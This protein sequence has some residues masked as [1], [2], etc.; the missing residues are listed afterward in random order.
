M[1]R[2]RDGGELARERAHWYV[3]Y[4]HVLQSGA[5]TDAIAIQQEWHVPRVFTENRP[6]YVF[7]TATISGRLADDPIYSSLV[8]DAST[9]QGST[10]PINRQL[11]KLLFPPNTPSAYKDW[12]KRDVPQLFVHVILFDDA[13]LL[14]VRVPHAFADAMSLGHIL[15]AWTVV[16]AGQSPPPIIPVDQPSPTETLQ[17]RTPGQRSVL[18]HQRTGLFTMMCLGLDILILGKARRTEFRELCIPH[19]A[20]KRMQD[21]ANKELAKVLGETFHVTETDVVCSWL[22]HHGFRAQ[23]ISPQARCSF[24]LPMDIRGILSD[25]LEPGTA[26]LGNIFDLTFMFSSGKQLAQD[27]IAT[28][29]ARIR[30]CLL[31]QRSRQELE[32]RDSVV[33]EFARKTGIELTSFGYWNQHYSCV[34]SWAK[35][36][37]YDLDF[38]PARLSTCSHAPQTCTP[39]SIHVDPRLFDATN[40]PLMGYIRGKDANENWWFYWSLSPKAWSYMEKEL[41]VMSTPN[42]A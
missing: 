14:S 42:R 25:V 22:L 23:Q 2:L 11:P 26:A 5:D 27:S 12:R 16:L 17:N 8:L 29:A 30:R 20:L 21:E 4:L 18:Y 40:L 10:F 6:G 34:S 38:G 15:K 19:S 35:A 39:A 7:T 32:A 13:T 9:A 3:S 28:T 33:R 24:G 37:F 41:R 36:G 31:T 1:L